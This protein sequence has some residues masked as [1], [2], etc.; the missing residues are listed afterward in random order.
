MCYRVVRVGPRWTRLEMT[1]G[2]DD[3]DFPCHPK[4]AIIGHPI[5]RGIHLND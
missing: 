2:E 4:Y 5:R 1:V 3:P